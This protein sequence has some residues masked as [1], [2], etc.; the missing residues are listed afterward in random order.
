MLEGEGELMT[1]DKFSAPGKYRRN[2][3]RLKKYIK[4]MVEIELE[5]NEILRCL[6]VYFNNHDNSESFLEI[7]RKSYARESIIIPEAKKLSQDLHYIFSNLSHESLSIAVIDCEEESM[8]DEHDDRPF[9]PLPTGVSPDQLSYDAYESTSDHD[10]EEVFVDVQ[11]ESD[12][13]CLDSIQVST[14]I[15]HCMGLDFDIVTPNIQTNAILETDS[16]HDFQQVDIDVESCE[17]DTTIESR[18]TTCE[19]V[20]VV[21]H[22]PSIELEC[23]P[24]EDFLSHMEQIIEELNEFNQLY[25]ESDY[26][27]ENR[28]NFVELSI[29]TEEPSNF[30]ES[31]EV[32][33]ETT[34][35]TYEHLELEESHES[36][37]SESSPD[38]SGDVETIGHS[39]SSS[40]RNVC[41]LSDEV[42]VHI[43]QENGCVSRLN[44][45][46]P[47]ANF[48]IDINTEDDTSTPL[49]TIFP[50]KPYS[51]PNEL[52]EP[53]D[54][55]SIG[56]PIIVP[57]DPCLSENI[58]NSDMCNKEAGKGSDTAVI[59]LHDNL[60]SPRY[61]NNSD[62]TFEEIHD[63][64]VIDCDGYSDTTSIQE[65]QILPHMKSPVIEELG[66]E[67]SVTLN[68][69]EATDPN[70]EVD[71]ALEV[72]KVAIN[73]DDVQDE[74][75]DMLCSSISRVLGDD[76]EEKPPGPPF[77]RVKSV[78]SSH[79]SH[80]ES[81]I[82][83]S[84]TLSKEVIDWVGSHF[85]SSE[86]DKQPVHDE[87]SDD[88]DEVTEK[89]ITVKNSSAHSPHIISHT[90]I[91]PEKYPVKVCLYLP[92]YHYLSLCFIAMNCYSMHSLLVQIFYA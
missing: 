66:V 22:S 55:V 41:D 90:I 35:I 76:E 67:K 42:L 46:E 2:M 10:G 47:R 89:C 24:D 87:L 29:I 43:D 63:N 11:Y 84:F 44:T 69:P 86:L 70:T 21:N 51:F 53:L 48:Y 65:I 83:K 19:E 73:D 16:N 32:I 39:T 64:I 9:T 56:Q 20:I 1:T 91:R 88:D 77:E 82:H 37:S 68:E 5:A 54:N 4:H 92:L 80:E 17:V 78:D 33:I 3:A 8:S 40:A 61:F 6:Q 7:N 27:I 30:N 58:I 72:L 59:S 45:I 36:S 28:S 62:L 71:V 57:L 79:S 23:T 12:E 74:Y 50:S 34:D 31:E 26:G 81:F 18:N 85:Q 60:Y 13:N 52:D 75:V 15:S 14:E 49:T 25:E 38:S